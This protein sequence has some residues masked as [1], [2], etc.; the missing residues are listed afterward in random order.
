MF[1]YTIQINIIRMM[2]KKKLRH[3]QL[4]GKPCFSSRHVLFKD[5]DWLYS[6]G[7]KENVKNGRS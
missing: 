2:Y 6:E 7:G 4:C 1:C 5:V 3:S